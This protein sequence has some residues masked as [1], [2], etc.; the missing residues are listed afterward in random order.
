M[1]V[2]FKDVAQLAGVSTQTV[3][4]VTN[5]SEQVAEKTR[6]RVN[7]AIKQ[8]GYVPNKGAQ[9]LS[10]AKSK[11]IGLI[12]LDM[13]LHGAALI[14]N[15]V[16]QKAHELKYGVAFSVV[17]Q[18]SLD[19]IQQ[20]I[21]ELTAQQVDCVILNVPLTSVDAR[22]LLEQFSHLHLIFIDVPEK[23]NVHHICGAH[24][25]GAKQAAEH[26]IL[27]GRSKFLLITGPNESS[28]S[29]IRLH[30]WQSVIEKNK[31][32]VALQYE[33]NW[34]AESGYMAVRQ[35][36]SKQVSFD[37]V[38]VASDQ[39]ALGALRALEEFNIAVPDQAAVVGFDGIADSAFFSP[40]LTT[41]KQDFT[42]IGLQ[43]VVLALQVRNEELLTD[44]YAERVIPVTLLERGSSAPRSISGYKK[45]EI[46]AL[47]QR[48]EH[49]LPET[50]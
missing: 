17:S 35:A 42:E 11:S 43:A 50:D 7:Q 13:A 25:E 15:G 48:I 46:K 5:G 28:A 27:G 34:Q 23:S 19:N 32:T 9:M 20:S 49:L 26:L 41:I 24:R 33:G 21:R 39:M 12:T 38:L 37:A 36:I 45:Q 29:T 31:S 1:N 14:A 44:G 47:L 22:Y 8:L 6:D 10:R 40:P 16:R 2:T 4:R 18:P 30:S 3:S